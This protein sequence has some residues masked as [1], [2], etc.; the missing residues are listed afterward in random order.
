MR[1]PDRRPNQ[2]RQPLDCSRGGTTVPSLGCVSCLV[3]R[4]SGTRCG[5]WMT[6][7]WWFRMVR[8]ADSCHRTVGGRS[9]SKPATCCC[10]T[11]RPAEDAIAITT[12]GEDL[13]GY[14]TRP[15]AASTA[16]STADDDTSGTPVTVWSPDSR[17]VVVQLLDERR[18]GEL[19]V[20]E[21]LPHESNRR[22]AAHVPPSPRRRGR[23]GA[24][25][26][27]WFHPYIQRR[28]TSYFAV[29]L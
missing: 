9:W 23:R 10:S 12:D 16:R 5:R 29:H 19:H 20:V 14:G 3:G 8:C 7:V 17:R 15:G 6:C 22:R 1:A 27:V 25:H 21:H 2:G 28:V 4:P 24:D 26:G 11:A 18:V 13:H